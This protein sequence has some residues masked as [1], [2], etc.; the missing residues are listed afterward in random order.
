MVEKNP[1]V[2]V[3]VTEQALITT[4]EVWNVFVDE[5]CSSKAIG[6]G[7]VIFTPDGGI[8][9]QGIQIEFQSI[10]NVVEYEAILLALHRLR[11]LR[12]HHVVMHSD[13]RLV[14]N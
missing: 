7:I 11:S 14:V 1:P 5:V 9:E 13:S 10:N 12:A 8:I 2:K 3:S 4:L 6:I